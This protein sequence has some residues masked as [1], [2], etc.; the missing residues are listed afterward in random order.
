MRVRDE[1]GEGERHV[2]RPR[3]ESAELE[4]AAPVAE[5]H[6]CVTLPVQHFHGDAG[7][8][9]A[10][11]IRD[12]AGD[13]AVLGVGDAGDAHD[14]G[15]KQYQSEARRSVITKKLPDEANPIHCKMIIFVC[16][17]VFQVIHELFAS[18]L[19]SEL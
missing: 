18:S 15:K 13:H 4:L 14:E 19:R 12:R 11:H 3:D 9:G 10:R 6:L 7:E 5:G 2:V 8:E 1:A 16:C 17:Y